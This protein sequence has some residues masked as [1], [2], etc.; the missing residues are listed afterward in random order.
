MEMINLNLQH[1]EM[2]KDTAENILNWKYDSPYDFYNN[3]LN[4]EE[5]AE[6]LNGSYFA[7]Y[8]DLKELIGFFCTGYSAQVPTGKK[9]GMYEENFIDMGLGM[10]PHLV[11]RGSGYNFCSYILKYIEENH[12]KNPIRLTVAEFNSRAIHLY[13]KLG[14]V[15]MKE[16]GTG[17]ADFTIM[18]K[19]PSM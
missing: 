6:M 13:K 9:L 15:P 2:D 1:T 19:R 14:F 7:I 18:V 3:E 17:F 4:E 12:P 11:G 10:N 8:N 5:L 16:F